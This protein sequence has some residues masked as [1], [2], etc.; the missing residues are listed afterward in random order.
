[1]KFRFVAALLLCSLLLSACSFSLASDITPPPGYVPAA[2]VATLGPVFPAEAPNLSAGAAIFAEKCAPCHGE[3]GLGDG[4]QGQQLGVSVPALGTAELARLAAPAAWYATVTQGRID[5][6]MPPFASLTDAE[7][8]DVISYAMSLSAPAEQVTSGKALYEENCAG[9]HGADG[10]KVGSADLSN[11]EF[12]ASRSAHDLYQL[13]ADGAGADMPGF[14][15]KLS[16]DELWAVLAYVRTFTTTQAAAPTE[17]NTPDPT[18]TATTLPSSTPLTGTPGAGE[19]ISATAEASGVPEVTPTVTPTSE[20]SATA[21]GSGTITGAVTNGSG[22]SVPPGLTATLHGLEHGSSSTTSNPEVLTTAVPVGDDGA[23]RFENVE[24]PVN[25]LFYVTIDYDGTSFFSESQVVAAD[26]TSLELPVSIYESTTDTSALSISQAH[27]LMDITPGSDSAQVVEFVII[28][29]SGDKMVVAPESGEPPVKIVLPENATNVVFDDNSTIGSSDRYV[30]TEKGFGDTSNVLPGE[31]SGQIV[32][33][34]DI[35]Y[36][37]NL[38]FSQT[39]TLPVESGSVLVPDGMSVQGEGFT[40]GETRDLQG[41]TFA[42]WLWQDLPAGEALT[43]SLSGKPNTDT[44]TTSPSTS[45]GGLIVGGVAL[46]VALLGVGVWFLLRQRRAER[47]LE[48]EI[49]DGGPAIQTE[50]DILDAIIAL[51]DQYRAGN[52]SE[53]AYRARREE[54]KAR[55]KK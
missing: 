48:V 17:T 53:E 25:R 31:A 36:S 15:D 54:L 33:G 49:E 43:F 13:T 39:Y 52:I 46:I 4:P 27:V 51:D 19:T 30:A 18:A 55:L 24:M 32:Y 21:Q 37:R 22:G 9:C 38:E 5:K 12:M 42:S 7:R 23:F 44:A 20:P 40:P 14:K 16:E 35:P 10:A 8:W 1:M 3:R 2:P 50:E 29:N 41:V 11:Q 45:Q 47:E 28:S 26:T 6:F 34:F